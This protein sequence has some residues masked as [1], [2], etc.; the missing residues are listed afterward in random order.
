[1]SPSHRH[2]V[3]ATM[4]ISELLPP[5]LDYCEVERGLANNTQ[6]NYHHYLTTFC[7]WLTT[8]GNARLTPPQLTAELI[9]EYRLYLARSHK[10]PRGEYL[11]KKSQNYYLIAL[12]AFVNFLA[13][14]DIPTLPAAK[15]K[16]AKQPTEEHISFLTQTEL[17]AMLDV[18]RTEKVQGLRDRAI[19]E[20]LFS[21]GMRVSE[22]VALNISTVAPL[23]DK[24]TDRTYELSILGKGKRPRTVFIS[25]RAA[26]WIRAYLHARRDS[27]SPLF[28]NHSRRASVEQR[29]TPRAIQNMVRQT[30]LRAGISKKVTPHT[31]RHSYATD[32]LAHGADLRSVQELLGHRNVATTQVYT[33]VTNKRLRD[34]H[35]RFHN[36]GRT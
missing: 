15:I 23:Q 28:L 25:P 2:T 8:T 16:L 18:P 32:L 12:R 14:R 24:R 20:L 26:E 19:L 22:L 21:S 9:W 6:R 17:A 5:F 7:N 1:M 34:I 3:T 31:L 27:A 29:L 11:A 10:T 35:E 33:H 30:A 13:D 36:E 4:T